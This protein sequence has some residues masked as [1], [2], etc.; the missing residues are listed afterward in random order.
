VSDTPRRR[1]G[2]RIALYVLA[3]VLALGLVSLMWMMRHLGDPAP[4]PGLPIDNR[5]DQGLLIFG[6]T[7][8]HGTSD[9]ETDELLLSRI[10][11]H[12]VRDSGIDCAAGELVARTKDGTE[13]A[14]RGPFEACNLTTWVIEAPR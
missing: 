2:W 11:S 12:A 14:R 3:G 1:S 6:I 13:I 5:T 10:G 9:P 4:E 8:P 7:H